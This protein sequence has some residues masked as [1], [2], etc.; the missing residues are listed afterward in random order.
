MQQISGT[1]AEYLDAYNEDLR[2]PK[3]EQT[4][5]FYSKTASNEQFDEFFKKY[6]CTVL[7]YPKESRICDTITFYRNNNPTRIMY[8]Y[9]RD[10]Y[11]NNNKLFRKDYNYAKKHEIEL[12]KSNDES[13][14]HK[15]NKLREAM[16]KENCILTS[17]YIKSNKR[18]HYTF[19]GMDYALSPA[20]WYKGIRAH[21]MKCIRYT[22]EHIKQLFA[23]EGCELI[24]K[25]V[26][27]KSRLAYK[28]KGKTFHVVWNDWNYYNSRPHLGANKTYFS[29]E[30]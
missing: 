2:K 30:N 4:M 19:E 12:S 18:V 6:D 16:L 3:D 7:R 24:S 20:N 8:C 23:K 25:Y 22:H 9:I 1:I 11:R 15:E 21:K 28:Y 29:E 27:Q 5:N 26:N 10:F 17:P 14:Q 13:R